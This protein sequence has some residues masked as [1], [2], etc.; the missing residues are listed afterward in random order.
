MAKVTA[1]A[2]QT[3]HGSYGLATEGEKIVLDKKHAEQLEKQGALEIVGEAGDESTKE[4]SFSITDNTGKKEKSE[5]E[6][7]TANPTG[8][9]KTIN[10]T[11]EKNANA[12]PERVKA[13]ELIEKIEAAKT[14]KQ[15]DQLVGD[16]ERKTVLDAAEKKK[17]ELK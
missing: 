7:S 2:K 9:K 14:A 16:D 17:A 13:S 1:I 6:T 8:E 4:T 5:Q 3:L 11:P 12:G 15:V 10:P